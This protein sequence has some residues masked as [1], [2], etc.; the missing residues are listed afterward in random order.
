M[1]YINLSW[2]IPDDRGIDGVYIYRG[3]TPGEVAAGAEPFA[4]LRPEERTFTDL[5]PVAGAVRFYYR[6]AI[7]IGGWEIG[8]T[9]SISPVLSLP[10]PRLVRSI[11]DDLDR[12]IKDGIR[13]SGD[14]ASWVDDFLI[15]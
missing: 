15:L 2:E 13:L 12:P 8:T 1:A 5:A 4:V 7:R 9:H 14:A 11:P 10:T 6:I 3:E